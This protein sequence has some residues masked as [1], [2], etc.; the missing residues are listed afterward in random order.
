[1]NQMRTIFACLIAVAVTGNVLTSTALAQGSTNAV[2]LNL[3][4]GGADIICLASDISI[5]VDGT[6]LLLRADALQ[7]NLGCPP[8][9]SAPAS[10]AEF[11]DVNLRGSS[12]ASA[13]L[14]LDL[15]AGGVTDKCLQLG[16]SA[17]AAIDQNT[18]MDLQ[19][20][21]PDGGCPPPAVVTLND[22]QITPGTLNITEGDS[23]CTVG[24][25]PR[26]CLT[27][28][29]NSSVAP[30]VLTPVCQV[31]QTAPGGELSMQPAGIDNPGPFVNP[32]NPGQFVSI[33][34]DLLWPVNPTSATTGNKSFRLQCEPGGQS[35]TRTVSF[36]DNRVIINSFN[37]AESSAA[38]G[39][40]INYSWNLSVLG[41]PANPTCT[42][43]SL[44]PGVMNPIN[45]NP[46]T[47][48]VGSAMTNLQVGAPLGTQTIRLECSPITTQSDDSITVTEPAAVQ[49]QSFNIVENSVAPG[50]SINFS[51]QLSLNGNPQNPSCTLTAVNPGVISAPVTIN[52]PAT[53]G[54]SAV[55]LLSSAPQGAQSFNFTCLPGG[56]SLADSLN[57]SSPRVIP[58][59][60]SP[61]LTVIRGQLL[62][63]SWSAFLASNPSAPNCRISSTAGGFLES[64]PLLINLPSNPSSQN[65]SGSVQVLASSSLGPKL[66]RFNCLPGNEPA[67]EVTVVVVDPPPAS[68]RID[69][70]NVIES[71]AP[72]GGVIN[73]SYTVTLI[74]NPPNPG[75]T[76]DEPTNGTIQTLPPFSLDPQATTQSGSSSRNVR[77]SAAPGTAQIRF[78]CFPNLP[79]PAGS[80]QSTDSV[81]IESINTPSVGIQT[82]DIVQNSINPD[83]SFTVN[84][85]VVV[86]G[87]PTS[88][89]CVLSS[90]VAGVIADVMIN[91]TATPNNQSG[92]FNVPLLPGGPTGVQLFELACSPGSSVRSDSLQIVPPGA[93]PRIQINNFQPTQTSAVRGETIGFSWNVTLIDNPANPVCVLQS[94]SV[95]NQVSVPLAVSPANQSG[96]S[97]AVILANA[98]TGNQTFTFSCN[99][100]SAQSF[101]TALITAPATP[102]IFIDDFQIVQSTATPGDFIDFSWAITLVNSPS[103]VDC[104][105]SSTGTI[106]QVIVPVSAASSQSG[107][108][109]VQILGTATAGSKNFNF[110]CTATDADQVSSTRTVDVTTSGSNPNVGIIDFDVIETSASQGASF[111]F[112]WSVALT[113]ISGPGIASCTLDNVSILT[114][115]VTIQLD[116]GNGQTQSGTSL[117]SLR[118][119]A[120]TGAQSLS[121]SCTPGSSI[122]TDSM[123]VQQAGG[124]PDVIINNFNIVETDAARGGLI[125]FDWSVT[126]VD[127][128]PM[129]SCVLSSDTS[130]VINDFTL[131]LPGSPSLQSGS[132]SINISSSASTG[133]QGFTFSCSPGNDVL[134]DTVNITAVPVPRI[135]INNFNII[136]TGAAQ[137][138]IINFSWSVTLLNNPPS[139]Q[140]ILS[141][142]TNGVINDEFINLAAGQAN[143]TGAGSV[144]INGSASTG[145][146]TFRFECNP[147]GQ[148]RTDTVNITTPGSLN[149]LFFDVRNVSAPRLSDVIFDFT[150]QRINNPVNPECTLTSPGVINPV[151]VPVP[152]AGVTVQPIENQMATILLN[153]PLGQVD[154]TLTCMPGGQT[155]VEQVTIADLPNPDITI[156]LFNIIQQSASPGDTLQF[157]YSVSR[158][159]IP[160]APECVLLPVPNVSSEIIIPIPTS[161]PATVTGSADLPLLSTATAGTRQFTFA[162]RIDSGSS[163]SDAFGDTV[164]IQ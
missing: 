3:P 78:R 119:D 7:T 20:L 126:L 108:G 38:Q 49:L 40:Q 147:D 2:R 109:S 48:P 164:T 72:V 42:I 95:I 125:N 36:A 120:A 30:G 98:P 136:E 93:N 135:D 140:C 130:G 47:N 111:N 16:S 88:P 82:F 22:F 80:T 74:N 118:A 92:T 99:P 70:F 75:C 144:S 34:N 105:L 25:Q 151:T 66:L 145:S 11:N 161:G 159:G 121:F 62:N 67:I 107:S 51:W 53:S 14:R 61:D 154:F 41:N 10:A 58:V 79:S 162:C 115:P 124:T 27:L 68:V 86:S 114:A 129:V 63:F 141:S 54:S 96:N 153:A 142:N 76:I 43:F 84:W 117:A 150:V 9:A 18:F 77:T 137:G 113:D 116:P 15:P 32:G 100:G 57:V 139:P 149:L 73:F 23:N 132:N 35:I 21:Q 12:N 17:A 4:G 123:N 134:A 90:N 122:R 103:D 71:S 81:L 146:Q 143:Q 55:N 60:F 87:N 39:A 8:G 65:G 131:N 128:P 91:L 110:S 29:W 26:Q 56:S 19:A 163:F 83:E 156:N 158:I 104:R 37:I 97:T 46:Q 50:D 160:L 157:D 89:G 28:S 44:T 152:T 31:T 101:A 64:N 155:A 148:F 52:N 5:S 127:A 13:I 106:D 6:E 138:G 112:S 85:S 94:S 102:E 45:I 24:G 1:V 59:S 133:S 33:E 69:N